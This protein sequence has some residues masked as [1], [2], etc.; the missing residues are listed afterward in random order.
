MGPV[1]WNLGALLVYPGRDHYDK[2]VVEYNAAEHRAIA[3]S[4][5]RYARQVQALLDELRQAVKVK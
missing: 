1:D 4:E 5:R 2:G 3:R